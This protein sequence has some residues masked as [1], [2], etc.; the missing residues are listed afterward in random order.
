M[1]GPGS[2]SVGYRAWTQAWL[3]LCSSGERQEPQLKSSS[4]GKEQGSPDK[5]SQQSC[6]GEQF[7]AFFTTV[8][9][10]P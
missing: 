2:A 4:P 9:I 1:I 10:R 5:V 6:L 7:L 8:L 3:P